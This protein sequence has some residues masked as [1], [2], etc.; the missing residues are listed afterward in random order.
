MRT[1][2]LLQMMILLGS[3]YGYTSRGAGEWSTGRS[4]QRHAVCV[5]KRD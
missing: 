2:G 3:E 1:A 5:Q 4:F